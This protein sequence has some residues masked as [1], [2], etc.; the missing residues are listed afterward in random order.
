M[1]GY[2]KEEVCNR[3]GCIGI[4][5]EKDLDGGCS[6]H[7]NP[8][9]G[10]CTTPKEYCPNC[11]WDAEQEDLEYYLTPFM[12]QHPKPRPKKYYSWEYNVMDTKYKG[13]DLKPIWNVCKYWDEVF[14]GV[15]YTGLT[16]EQADLKKQS[17]SRNI[18]TSFGVTKNENRY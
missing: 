3:D 1:E 8:P 17:L 15:V 9:C 13:D 6:C 18:Y 11:N 12:L 4:I 2:E 7:I 16:R 14:D 10:Y 5:K